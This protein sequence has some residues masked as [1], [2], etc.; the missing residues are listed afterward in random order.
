MEMEAANKVNLGGSL[1]Q[2]GR[3]VRETG[4][5]E[6]GEEQ[7]SGG[8]VRLPSLGQ[9]RGGG[10]GW[11][12]TILMASDEGVCRHRKVCVCCSMIN[13]S[14]MNRWRTL[15]SSPSPL[16]PSYLS[17]LPPSFLSL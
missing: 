14:L 6:G 1:Q 11:G 7:Q 5:A 8:G 3:K 16:Q 13:E 2:V 10:G 9:S 17:S 15:L 12:G 4:G